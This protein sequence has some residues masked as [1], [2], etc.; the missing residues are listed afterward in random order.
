MEQVTII[1]AGPA[2]LAAALQLKRGGMT[3]LLLERAGI[4]GL[5]RN[6]QLVAN[7]PGFPG[8]VSGPELVRLFAE[9]AARASLEVT[10]DE[11]VELTCPSGLFQIRTRRALYRSD[12]VVIASGTRPVPFPEGLVPADA[13]D[14]LSYEVHP[15]REVAGKTL[16]VVGAGDAAFDYALS[17]AERNH[18]TILNR[19]ER[20]K[21][22]PVLWERASA[23]PHISYLS[24]TSI[25]RMAR[26]SADCLTLECATPT[27][28]L[29]LDIH[30]LIGALGREPELGFVSGEVRAQMTPLQVSGRLHIIGDVRNGAFRQTAIAAGEGVRAGM[31]IVRRLKESC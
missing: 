14:L 27:T 20:V 22:L 4:G 3:P 5:L 23:N 13:C 15:I 25:S 10:C 1:G 30:Y 28:T 6:A 9:Q 16:A 17:L 8:G 2:G 21:C 26:S 19:G 11:V 24:S 29:R 31:E 7:Y 18:V 12:T